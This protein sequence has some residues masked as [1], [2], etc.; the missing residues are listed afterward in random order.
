MTFSAS[1]GMER[2][3]GVTTYYGLLRHEPTNWK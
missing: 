1:N 3:Y 2:N